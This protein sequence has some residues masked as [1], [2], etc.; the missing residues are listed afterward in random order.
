MTHSDLVQRL[1]VQVLKRST[2]LDGF[3]LVTMVLGL[4]S[5]CAS[6]YK[7]DLLTVKLTKTKCI[8]C[9]NSQIKSCSVLVE[10]NGSRMSLHYNPV[11]F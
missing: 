10:L 2:V 3:G 4:V 1:S 9:Y 8:R 11:T 5:Y 7:S 6:L